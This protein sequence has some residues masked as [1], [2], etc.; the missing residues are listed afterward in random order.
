MKSVTWE[1]IDKTGFTLSLL[2]AIHCIAFPL[3]LPFLPLLAG[4]FIWS[5]GFEQTVVFASLLVAA[6]TLLRGY[7]QHRR[8]WVPVAFVIGLCFVLLRPEAHVH[9]DGVHLG[10]EHYFFASCT[11]LALASGHWLNLR[12]CRACPICRHHPDDKPCSSS[13]A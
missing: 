12:F 13:K 6:P 10:I 7:A 2:C 8:I 5:S 3:L 9:A 11:G 1:Q 4:S